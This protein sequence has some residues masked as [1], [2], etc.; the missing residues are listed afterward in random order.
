M[1][2]AEAAVGTRSNP[3]KFKNQEYASLRAQCLRSGS[4]FDDPEFPAQQDS[5]G[6][7]SDP[8]PAKA[9]VWRRPKEI[10]KEPKFIE[11]T[12]ST[13]D[14]CQGQLGDCWLLA[15]LSC[16]TLHQPLFNNV[17][18][19]DQSLSEEY[20]G[21]FH[22]KFWQ[23]GQ[24][25]EVVVDDRLPVQ[26]GRLLFSY[27]RTQNE[28]WSALLEKAYA[29]VN[30]CYASL[31]GGNISEAMEDFTGGIA[32]SL[33]VKSR[34]PAVLWRAVGESLSR[35]TLLSCFIQPALLPVQAASAA[36]VGKVT[37]QG[38]VKGHAYSITDTNKVKDGSAEVCLFRLRNP[39]GFVEYCGPWS[40]KCEDW[41][42]VDNAEKQRIKL[43]RAED[44]EFWIKADDLSR[45]FTT[46]EMCSVNPD[47]LGGAQ[48]LW[49]IT[50]HEGAWVP[51]CSA[52][53]SRKFRRTFCKNPQFRLILTQ[54]DREEVA[55]GD[56]A[57]EDGDGVD[58]EGGEVEQAVRPAGRGTQ[59]SVVLELL[60][61][62][63]RQ[64]DKISF[65]Y[66]AF[67]VYR[68]PP[69]LQD[70]P[71]SLAADFFSSNKPVARSGK[72]RQLRGVRKKV[73]LEPGHYVIVV[74]SYK[75]NVE[76]SFFLRIYAKTG[77]ELGNQGGFD[78]S[79]AFATVVQAEPITAEDR[80]TV[81]GL[82]EELAGRDYRLNAVEL[83]RLASSVFPENFQLSL[84]TCRS[85]I[86]GEDVSF[87]QQRGRPSFLAEASGNMVTLWSDLAMKEG[88]VQTELIFLKLAISKLPGLQGSGEQRGRG[89]L[90][91][92]QT[93][94]LVA[95]LR[96]L[97]AIFSQFDEDSSGTMSPFELSLALQAAGFQLDAPVLQLLWLRHGTADLS[98][99]FDGLVAC[100]GRLRKLF[101]LYE[102]EGSS[103]VKE[104]GI[105]A[106]SSL[107]DP[108]LP[109]N[110]SQ[111]AAS[112]LTFPL[113][114]RVRR[115]RCRQPVRVVLPQ[116]EGHLQPCLFPAFAS[117]RSFTTAL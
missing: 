11:G 10:S 99:T 116:R 96:S 53:G 77:N 89:T 91:L 94:R 86:F 108:L 51:G 12:A 42:R 32:R 76:G 74:S 61:K 47:A 63:R 114:P 29:K 83:V 20:A 23:Y 71:G 65:L 45:L 54:Q 106:V 46:V 85:L 100:V 28:F 33:P 59:S 101:D 90:S 98:L 57:A 102:S 40:D 64:K 68:V 67:H 93:E 70:V 5:L 103:E 56:E 55:E 8:D 7:P 110:M 49:R 21:I 105:N 26:R 95:S 58:D 75:P 117:S 60:Q 88:R 82:F 109:R 37:P 115:R 24:W 38:L 73:K 97:Q 16:L 25:V 69:E 112:C 31:K 72:Y 34:T 43:I 87:T 3:A 62:H 111:P 78:C 15:A 48:S 17:V 107:P 80:G 35:G 79:S 13:T 44:G 27:S 92:G 6:L 84:E 39:W 30:G 1:S 81:R 50:A 22:F 18:P 19:G 4:L 113:G 41:D 36:E 14:I 104:R 66:I 52:G 9:V 2:S